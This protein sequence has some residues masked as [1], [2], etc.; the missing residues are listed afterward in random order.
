M[1]EQTPG[2]CGVSVCDGAGEVR[3]DADP[4]DLPDDGVTCT[5]DSCDDRCEASADA[6]A[7][8]E[9]KVERCGGCIDDTHSELTCQDS[10]SVCA[11]ECADIYP[12]LTAS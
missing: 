5:V 10:R 8:Y 1:S 2:D 9:E 11:D 3:R 6:S 12:E 4:D 7:S